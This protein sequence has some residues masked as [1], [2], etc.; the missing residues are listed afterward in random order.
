MRGRDFPN[1]TIS[2]AINAGALNYF[3][4]KKRKTIALIQVIIH[5]Y[6]PN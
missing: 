5:F 3:R 4:N 6:Q 1:S 2:N